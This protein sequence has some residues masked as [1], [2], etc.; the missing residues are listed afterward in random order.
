MSNEAIATVSI[1]DLKDGTSFTVKPMHTIVSQPD[2]SIKIVSMD[3]E[4]EEKN[5]TYK[6]AQGAYRVTP[7]E[8]LQPIVFPDTTYYETDESTQLKD[9]FIRRFLNKTDVFK[10]ANITPKRSVLLSSEPGVGK[11]SC[12]QN[13]CKNLLAENPRCCVLYVDSEEVSTEI[14]IDMFRS[15]TPETA[16]DIDF[17]VLITE[18]IGGTDL[19]RASSRVCSD[20]LNFMDGAPG[21]FNIPT[22]HILTTNFPDEL[23]HTLTERPGRVDDM[24]TIKPPSVD[25]CTALARQYAQ[26]ISNRELSKEE[27]NH[28]VGK[29]FSPAYIKEIV[30]RAELYDITIEES[31]KQLL[32]QRENSRKG[33]HLNKEAP[34][35]GFRSKHSLSPIDFDF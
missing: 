2:G 12:I 32:K 15:A 20:L 4:S 35:A 26:T 34:V 7:K 25:G 29:D 5:A 1:M 19:N 13:F 18:D 33:T 31:V 27:L 9:L 10:R 6:I 3:I 14:L 30:L 23:A 11:S 16:T 22:L 8:G 28:L 24:I 17:I 21:I